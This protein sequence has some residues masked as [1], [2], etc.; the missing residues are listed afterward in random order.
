M[1]K[2]DPKSSQMAS[3]E[4]FDAV[5]AVEEYLKG[6]GAPELVADDSSGTC[7]Y[8]DESSV[9]R[10]YMVYLSGQDDALQTGYC[11]GNYEMVAGG[12]GADGPTPTVISA[13]PPIGRPPEPPGFGAR[14]TT[15]KPFWRRDA[16]AR[17]DRVGS[18]CLSV[19]DY[20]SSRRAIG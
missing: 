18:G 15:I 9:G 3:W 1:V 17:A 20:R 16:C 12:E 19:F 2:G 11:S 8:F 13:V 14:A 4:D 10:R 5:L 6:T 7:G